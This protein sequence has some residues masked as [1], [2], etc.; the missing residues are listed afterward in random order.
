MQNKEKL[1][2]VAK[3]MVAP[4]KGLLAAD[5]SENTIAKRFNAVGIENTQENRRAY[6]EMLFTTPAIEE[7]ISGVILFDE[8]MHQTLR[9]AQGEKSVLF[10]EFLTGRGIIPGIKV[11]QGLEPFNSSEV[12]KVTKG[13]ETLQDRLAQ[14]AKMGAGFTKWRAVIA[15]KENELPTE[16]CV[17][18]N[19][20]R[21]AQY[22]LYSQEAGLVPIVEPEVLIDGNH[23]IERCREVIEKVTKE[24]FNQLKLLEVYLPGLILKSSMVLSG[25]ENEN[26]ADMATVAK[27][28][29]E[30]LKECVPAQVAGVV[31]LSGGQADKQATENLN[32]IN[33]VDNAPWPLTFSYGRGLQDKPM[34]IWAGREENLLMAKKEFYNLAKQNS[35]AAQGKL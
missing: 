6:R 33:K 26:Q 32:E 28:T 31:F 11:D 16:A 14:Y 12:E 8:T 4:G 21:L 17:L 30:T 2:H 3:L 27:M 13:L 22:A 1:E 18:E 25:K 9:G 23:S 15:I 34:K 7:Y 19:T 5:E 10:P 20:K 29:V 24:L 35:L